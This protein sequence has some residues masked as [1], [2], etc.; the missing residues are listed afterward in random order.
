MASSAVGCLAANFEPPQRWRGNPDAE[1]ELA[2]GATEAALQRI[3]DIWEREPATRWDLTSDEIR[4]LG[5]GR[6]TV[7]HP[8]ASRALSLARGTDKN[9]ASSPLLIAWREATVLLAADLPNVEWG[10]LSRSFSR[11]DLLATTSTLKISHHGAAKAQHEIAIGKPPPVARASV[12]TPWTKG[13]RGRRLPRFE[14]NEGIHALLKAVDEVHLSSMPT[15]YA[16]S[17]PRRLTRATAEA[18]RRQQR[19][20]GELVLEIEPPSPLVTDAW[21]HV[22]VDPAGNV[23]SILLGNAAVCVVA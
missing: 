14:S 7:V 4:P 3:F 11:S 16:N 12:A 17:A 9:R 19:I 5:D 20:G 13:A 8:P 18:S 23:A 1:R 21:I 10:R 15:P 6:V 22:A 2:G